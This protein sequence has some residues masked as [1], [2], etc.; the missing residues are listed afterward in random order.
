[1]NDPLPNLALP[2]PLSV[3]S[4]YPILS[5]SV[6]FQVTNFKGNQHKSFTNLDEALSYL[7]L[8][9]VFVSSPPKH[10]AASAL[11]R[12]AI[13]FAAVRV[14]TPAAVSAAAAVAAAADA[15]ANADRT[16][17]GES[18]ESEGER[19]GSGAGRGDEEE[20][21]GGSV[22]GEGG[23]G[24]VVEEGAVRMSRG[25]D[26]RQR[27]LYRMEFDGASKGN[28]GRAGAGSVLWDEG[29]NEVSDD[30]LGQRGEVM[31][32]EVVEGEVVE[33]EVVGGEV[34]EGE[35][36]EGEVMEGEV[37][38]GEVMEGEVGFGVGVSGV[39]TRNGA[40]VNS[41]EGGRRRGASTEGAGFNSTPSHRSSSLLPFVFPLHL[42]HPSTP[43]FLHPTTIQ[44][45]P[46]PPPLP[47]AY[48]LPLILVFLCSPHPTP[49][50]LVCMREGVG[51][52]TCNMAEYRAF[53]GGVELALALGITRLHVQGD[54]MLV[55]MQVQKKWKVN[56]EMLRGECKQAQEL[57]TRFK[58]IS[59]RHVPRECNQLADLLSNEAVP[60]K[61]NQR[62]IIP[63][64]CTTRF[65][66][67]IANNTNPSLSLPFPKPTPQITQT[68]L[69]FPPPHLSP[70]LFPNQ[71]TNG[72]STAW[73]LTEPPRATDPLPSIPCAACLMSCSPQRTPHPLLQLTSPQALYRMGFD[74]AAKGNRPI[75]IHPMCCLLNVLLPSTHTSPP[76]P[77][78]IPPGALPHGALY[79][80]GFDGAAKGNRPI[81]IHP[82]C[83]LLNVLLPSTHTSPPPPTH[84]PP[85]AL[86][87][88]ALYRMG[89]DGAAKGNRP[90]AIHPMCCLLNV[91]L[92]STHTS[93]PP[94]THI[95]PGAL[96]HVALYRMGFDGAAKGNRPI[97]IHPMCCLLNVLLP[98]T[99][100]SPPPPTH[101]PP[102]ALPH[103][104][105]YR[106]GF[107]G[108]AKGNRPI[109]IHPMCC[110]L[111][112]LLPSTH[113]SP[114]PPTPITPGALSHGALYRMGF[115]GAA[116]GNRPIAI[117]PMCCL[118]NVLL[119]STHTSPPPPTPIPPGAL[120]HGALYRMELD[121]AAKGNRP[122]AIHPMCCL[123][124]VL[125]PS[126]HTSP[127]LPA[128]IPPGAL[129]HGALYR[130]GFDGAAKGNRP[131]AI[132]P[133]CCLLNVLLPSTH[134]SPPPPTHIPPGALPHGALYRMGFDGAAKGN[135]PIA[136]HPMCCLLNV[137]LPSTHTS[138]PPPTHIPPGALPH[139]ALYRMGFDGAA[140]GN[141]PI[142]IHPM[143]CLLNVLL[144]STHTS[145]PPPTPITPGALPHGA[146]YRM[147]FDGAAKGNRPIAIHPMC[148]LLNVLLPSTHTSPPPPTPIPPGALSHGA[149]Y[150]MELDGAAKGNRPMAIHP[151]CCLLNVLLPSTHTSPP[152]PAHIPPGA[153]PHGALY[154]MGFDGAAKGNR[155]IAIHPMCC[156][157][158]VL[159]PSTHTSPP[160]PTP[161][162][163][164]ALSPGALYRMGFDGA[165]KGNRPIAIH[166]MCCLL[167]VLLPSTHTSPPPPTHIPPGAL[168]HG[169]L[170]R[171]GFDGASKGNPGRAG[172]GCVLWEEHGNELVCMREG[173][174]HGTCN[175]AEYRAFIGG[176]ESRQALFYIPT[177]P[178]LLFLPLPFSPPSPPPHHPPA[179]VHAGRSGARHVQHGRVSWVGE[180]G[181]IKINPMLVALAC[182]PLLPF[183]TTFIFWFPVFLS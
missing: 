150:R 175:V 87:H 22:G 178:S 21:G 172:A 176:V 60:L 25:E 101:I 120:S 177:C 112:V 109:A 174:G 16:A 169:S 6:P 182:I 40:G 23:V 114:P 53:I 149:L 157:L 103:G 12:T 76:P 170:Y 128:H 165:A 133:M 118:L 183:A 11:K 171:M 94:P 81:A 14:T 50:Q 64:T 77:T 104:A 43:L 86:S 125:L 44:I 98:S 116:K 160:P 148:C 63:S 24:A 73:G 173:V 123:L 143:C 28:P 122:M 55:V 161:I 144:P 48:H 153:L 90:I 46:T 115:D 93:P 83:C 89:F 18:T 45:H 57:V 110:L 19:G 106:M 146:L 179:G 58:E 78:H 7:A 27:A 159:L 61:E 145:P 111:N 154:R 168:P 68:S 2:S 92:P 41:T 62:V 96:P 100:T 9:N 32:G 135:R 37:V 15:A 69:L 80:M 42:S 102:D 138:P 5:T 47:P 163:P 108:A 36:M 127:P 181:E 113:T 88:G 142:A 3:H 140:K 1:M 17:A 34:M 30:G 158:N 130:L 167:N 70:P 13:P 136:I 4:L 52:G 51:H 119:P 91:L 31:E 54:S 141:R 129:P 147:G 126:T 95:P 8:A 85:G 74:G 131:I 121:G 97:A 82:M 155:P 33:G 72:R 20:G 35:V 38:G 29:G 152:P 139:G 105:L 49:H 71:R 65:L 151:M 107:D 164:G 99:H 56:A 180:D 79:R 67:G 124:N 137:L 134:T 117:H 59:I 132:H 66:H 156:L 26:M 84:I 10:A 166:P 75:A 162:P 39:H